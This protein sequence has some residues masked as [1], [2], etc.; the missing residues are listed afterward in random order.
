MATALINPYNLY[1]G[2]GAAT[3]FA[4]N[5]PYFDRSFVGVYLKRVDEDEVKL[6]TD[7]YEFLSD[8]VIKFPKDGSSLDVLGI[9]DK[10]AIQRETPIENEYVFDNQ[11]RLFPVDVMNADDKSYQI[12]QEVKHSL[13]KVVSIP[14][15]SNE[16]PSDYFNNFKQE[17]EQLIEDG[18]GWA[19]AAEGYADAAAD[20]AEEAASYAEGVRF[21]MKRELIRTSDWQQADGLYKIF[22][23]DVGIISDVYKAGTNKFNKVACNIVSSETGV[24]IESIEPF[25]GYVLITQAVYSQYIHTQT[26]ASDTWTIEHNLGEYPAVTAIDDDGYVM[27]ATIQYVDL[28]TVE[29][30]FTEAVTGKA[31]LN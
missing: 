17:V 1:T 22:F 5:F 11:K 2:N 16:D 21:G 18:E 27:V 19:G 6:T 26:V 14:V 9:N 25:D 4:V 29:L 28:N 10:L 24:T 8:T 7:D 13:S 12:L 20:S 15:T 23:S 3:E 31:I 30:T